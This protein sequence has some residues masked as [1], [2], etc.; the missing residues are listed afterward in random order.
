M[1]TRSCSNY[2]SSFWMRRTLRIFPLYFLALGVFLVAAPAV[3]PV[4]KEAL[5]P[6]ADQVY[7]WTY[8]NNWIPMGE[9][10]R[11]VHVLGHFWSLA[12]E[13]QFYL[14]WPVV[15]WLVPPRILLR[16]CAVACV[17][18]LAARSWAFFSAGDLGMV[19]R[20]TVLRADALLYGAAGALMLRD[21]VWA[22]RLGRHIRAL[23]VLAWS[24]SALVLVSAVGT[25]Y[26]RM[27]VMTLGMA[28]FSIAFLTLILQAV[29]GMNRNSRLQ[30]FL[31]HP[32][33]TAT[34]RYS[35]GMYVWHWPAAY[36]MY[37]AYAPLGLSGLPGAAL[38]LAA[39]LAVTFALAWA[40]YEFFESPILTTKR[41]FAPRWRTA[42]PL[43]FFTAS[44]SAGSTSN[45]SP[46]MP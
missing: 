45:R 6:V 30:R 23:S 4:P 28:V 33:L 27:P 38:M 24:A 35:Y 41:F 32:W 3:L 22:R 12:V 29:L 31:C 8:L 16:G 25:H 10:G 9:E 46:T 44:V 34:G 17:L 18:I 42:Q 40:S 11:L 36:V 37:Y 5:P 43:A 19:Y 20:N 13:E 26:Y 39:G 2:F 1:D 21:E 7:Y 15:V 14:L